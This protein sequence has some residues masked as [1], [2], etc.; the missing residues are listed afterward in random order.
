MIWIRAILLSIFLVGPAQAVEPD[1]VLSD[2]F[3]EARARNLSKELRCIVCQ[4]ES[5]D[6][7]NA[8]LARDL[9][10]LVRER[11]TSGDSDRQAIDFIV[12]RYGEFV[13]LRPQVSGANIVL[14]LAAPV[15]FLMAGALAIAYLHGRSRARPAQGTP[16]SDTEEA[17]IAE[18]IKDD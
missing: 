4:N 10:I 3:L 18:L 5:I 2:P 16:L 1:E 15:V 17:R 8:S 13:L 11:L 7:S 14:W 6:E 9:R 12:A